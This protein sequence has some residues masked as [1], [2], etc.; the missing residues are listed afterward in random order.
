VARAHPLIWVPHY[1]EAL[2][3]R[4]EVITVGPSLAREDLEG[5]GKPHLASLLYKHDIEADVSELS[6]V[7]RL[8]PE[9]WIPHL[10]LTVQSG[11][12][13]IR[14][15]ERA[16]CPTAYISVDTWH[17]FS[18]FLRA[19]PYDFVFAA[20]REYVPLMQAAGSANVSW[21]PLAC[22]PRVHHPVDVPKEWDI[23]FVGS[24][25]R[26]V[27]TERVVRLE[28]LAQR[29][30]VAIDDGLPPEQMCAAYG[31][32]RMVFN[33]SIAQDVNMRVFEALGMGATLFTNRNA[34]RNGLLDLFKDG[35]HLVTYDDEDLVE[36]AAV[37]LSDEK[38]RERVAEAGRRE[39]LDRHSYDHRIESLLARVVERAPH[40]MSA[41]PAV[42]R[43]RTRLVDF[44]PNAPGDVVDIGLRLELSKYALK[45]RGISSL[46]GIS[47]TAA[48][49]DRRL[50]SYD[51]MLALPSGTNLPQDA[52]TV[53][54]D[55]YAPFTAEN[56][57]SLEVAHRMLRAGGT[58]IVSLRETEAREHG[59]DI[60]EAEAARLWLR[61]AGFALLDAERLP[62]HRRFVFIGRKCTR[63]LR[64][65]AVEIYTRH[66]IPG[67]PIESIRE[68]TP[69][70]Y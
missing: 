1:V 48:E 58:L 37:W 66:P 69:D 52:D 33:S 2:R 43:A 57:Q 41:P 13:P 39:A 6:E 8:L 67:R 22:N 45:S 35:T 20:Q 44:L 16:A 29:F 18:E 32:A 28:R 68:D 12:P 53:V 3:S 15:I 61:P 56:G 24:Y 50:G 42:M 11:L 47:R 9:G 14:G 5:F 10:L 40:M 60:D 54:L 27:H 38:A 23:V 30:R 65:L 63:T 7:E 25:T 19:R 26:A 4:C 34:E 62:N 17:D 36:Q 21:L 59:L 51:K 70:E 55:G 46:T 31:S 64:D 49:A